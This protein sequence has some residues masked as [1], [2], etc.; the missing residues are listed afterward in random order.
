MFLEFH[1]KYV[2][3][4]NVY[5]QN[6]VS[7]SSD[8]MLSASP[9]S[10]S[11]YLSGG[12]LNGRPSGNVC[13]WR[14]S[15]YW[16]DRWR[17]YGMGSVSEKNESW[18]RGLVARLSRGLRR[19]SNDCRRLMGTGVMSRRSLSTPNSVG[20]WTRSSYPIRGSSSSYRPGLERR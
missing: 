19:R 17:R 1:F 11:A 2:M 20:L 16:C 10:S 5:F 3:Q 7:L 12:R 14:L 13:D 15:E 4:I 8:K 6:L 9:A 18:S